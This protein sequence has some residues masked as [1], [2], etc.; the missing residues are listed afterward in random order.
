MN[1]RIV[2]YRAGVYEHRGFY[3][4]NILSD[5]KK[6]K[7]DDSRK[8]HSLYSAVLHFYC[9][10]KEG[11]K[12]WFQNYCRFK[13]WVDVDSLE[14]IT[15][16]SSLTVKQG[17]RRSYLYVR[18]HS[19]NRCNSLI[20]KYIICQNIDPLPHS[21]RQQDSIQFYWVSFVERFT[22]NCIKYLKCSF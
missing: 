17:Q 9:D 12:R 15:S 5:E 10:Y 2:F 13:K 18:F 1:C 6:K 7:T 19:E 21:Q 8:P 14:T 4:T 22:Q 3:M 11:L 20:C 16:L